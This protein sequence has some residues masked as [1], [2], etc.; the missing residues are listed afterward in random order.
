MVERL[1]A[2]G[3]AV[4]ALGRSEVWDWGADWGDVIYAVGLTADFRSRPFDTV[5][6]HVGLLSQVLQRAHFHSL[7]YLSSTRVYSG[8]VS[9]AEDAVLCARPGDPSDL[10]NLSKL[11]GE[12]LCLTLDRPTVR[13]A[14]LSN[15]VGSERAGSPDFIAELERQ[16][17]AG[18]IRLA[19]SPESAKDYIHIDDACNLLIEVARRG[20][21]RIYNVASG[22]N[23]AHARWVAHF[24][25]RTGCRVEVEPNAPVLRW[26]P[27]DVARVRSEFDYTPRAVLCDV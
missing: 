18:C 6:A 26:A 21:E 8:A 23:I 16:A 24:Q 14:R 13:V 3:D 10:Y 5:E 27:I 19:S 1:R 12:S 22:A 17:A 2:R 11:L 7:L 9:T 25:S 4:R 20:R 15:V